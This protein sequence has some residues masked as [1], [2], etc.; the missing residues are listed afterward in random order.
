MKNKIIITETDEGVEIE[1][2]YED[3][4]GDKHIERAYSEKDVHR[5]FH[6]TIR[7][8]Q[9]NKMTKEKK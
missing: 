1:H 5:L 9:M 4:S 3:I 6:K 7:K 2:H 8:I